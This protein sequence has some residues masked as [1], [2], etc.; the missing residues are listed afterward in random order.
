MTNPPQ[1]GQER[2]AAEPVEPLEPRPVVER[3]G[4]GLI[5]LV[6]TGVFG[7]LAAVAFASGE[8]FLAVMS[9]TGALMTLWAAAA[10]V[11]RG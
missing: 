1:T 2:D 5:A 10:T 8:Y 9:G 7:A 11:S 6:L 4:L 3:I